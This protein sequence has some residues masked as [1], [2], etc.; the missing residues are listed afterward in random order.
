MV[1]RPS[2][3]T[4]SFTLKRNGTALVTTDF[5]TGIEGRRLGVQQAHGVAINLVFRW[6]FLH[7]GRV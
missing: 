5:T 1:W 4:F 6:T 2:E 3:R 7:F